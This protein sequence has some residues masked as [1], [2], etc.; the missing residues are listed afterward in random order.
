MSLHHLANHLASKGRHGDTTL[1]HMT[2]DEVAG[3]QALARRNGTTLTINPHTGLPEAFSL[4]SLLPMAAGAALMMTGVGAPMAAMLVGGGTWAATGSLKQGLMAGLGAYGGAGLAGMAGAGA[5]A[6]TQAAAG[7]VVAQEA[8]KDAAAEQIAAQ[9]SAA[10]QQAAATNSGITGTGMG[11]T[12]APST[13]GGNF[14]VDANYSLAT[15]TG[16]A[17]AMG[18]TLTQEGTTAS[19]GT[20]A[21]PMTTTQSVSSVGGSGQGLT[22]PAYGGSGTL[23]SQG[24][25]ATGTNPIGSNLGTSTAATG[26]PETAGQTFMRRASANPEKFAEYGGAAIASS[27]MADE[28]KYTPPEIKHDSDMGQRFAYDSGYDNSIPG[29]TEPA[30][31]TKISNEEAKKL[32][33]FAEGGNVQFPYGES[34]IRMADGGTA[35]DYSGYGSGGIQGDYSGYGANGIQG[36]YT[37]YDAPVVAPVATGVAALPAARASSVTAPANGMV[38]DPVSRTFIGSGPSG[39]NIYKGGGEYGLSEAAEKAVAEAAAQAVVDSYGGGAAQ[40]GLM[41]SY[42]SGGTTNGG[43]I[44][45]LMAKLQ[46]QGAFAGEGQSQASDTGTGYT[47]DAKTKQYTPNMASGGGISTLGGYSDG[48]RLLKGPGD[49]MSDNIPATIGRKQPAR[50]ADGEFVIPADV[51]SHLGN[52]S[53]DAGAKQLYSMM[54]KIRTARTGRKAQGKQI[55]PSKYMPA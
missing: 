2:R 24:V 55:N 19:M 4:K 28:K 36:N 15:P 7:D 21:N 53:T 1:V 11:G 34:V 25:T 46:A 39:D 44:G 54:D 45:D 51:V 41:Q 12:M 6:G 8:A 18:S 9:Q 16:D 10:A 35:G 30:S 14:A 52:G 48:G 20:G 13:T 42:A 27:Q 43:M 47:Y 38:Y 26:A 29:R 31:Y 33:G 17:T 50:L 37:G 5:A 3:L 40:G 32:Y 23:S 22:T 49:G